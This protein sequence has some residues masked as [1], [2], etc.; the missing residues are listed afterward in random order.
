MDPSWDNLTDPIF[1]WA[2]QRPDAPAL[3]Q[4]PD[5]LSYRELA[6]LV[7]KAAAHLDGM[8][9]RQGECVAINLTSSIDHFI[10]SLGLLRL[11]ATT[12]EVA[13]NVQR[14]PDADLL[15]QFGVRNIF[16]EPM[17]A[18][19]AG[20]YPIKLDAGWRDHVARA[21]GDKRSA[22]N[23]E[24]IFNV[25]VSSGSTG[26]P[27]GTPTS[28]REYFRRMRMGEILFAGSDVLS[29]ARPANLL[30]TG[31]IAFSLYFLRAM[32]Q[33]F[34]GGSITI[35]PEFQHAV[36]LVRTIGVWDDAVAVVPSALC[37]VLISCA[38][39]QG[40]L[41]P[42]LRALL[43]GGGFVYPDEKLAMLE[44]VTPHFY[45]LYGSAGSGPLAVLKP[46][47]MGAHAASVG[48]PPPG[49]DVQV[50]DDGGRV[51]PPGNVGRLRFRR[52][53]GE[54]FAGDGWYYPG[55]NAELDAAGY[56]H[57]RG[58][59]AELVRRQGVEFFAAEIEAEIAQHPNVREVAVVGV[60]RPTAGDEVV[61]LVVTRGPGSH[62]ALA[63]FCQSRL[64]PAAGIIVCR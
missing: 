53:E 10:L 13:Y 30:L 34:V 28:H 1:H 41:Y 6:A 42:R 26:R 7:G 15:A 25:S 2:A 17:G 36:D 32:N 54:R 5:T 52:S 20:A 51:L 16:T 49:V 4:G 3:R 56:I 33:F 11:G 60:P 23:G 38:P 64:V 40:P 62:E 43:A 46:A 31:G 12:M 44:R 61:A 37:R 29:S 63:Q 55:D 14:A 58:R 27:Q 8:G 59:S 24:G 48:R 45:E 18:P 39:P 9:I 57:I 19:L 47:E 22:D 50:V 21:Q 35:L